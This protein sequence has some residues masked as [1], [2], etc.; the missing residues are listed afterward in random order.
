MRLEIYGLDGRRVA[1]LV[2]E[3][4]VAGIHSVTWAGL[5]D[6]GRSVASG[7]YMYAIDIGS[8]RRVGKMV[9]LK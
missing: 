4:Q 1:T 3:D 9:M 5:D 7:V 2:D 8:E 6:R